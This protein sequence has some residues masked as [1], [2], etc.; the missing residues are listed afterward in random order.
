MS[1][2]S[3]YVSEIS[4]FGRFYSISVINLTKIRYLNTLKNASKNCPSG[5]VTR[6]ISKSG[7][8]KNK[9]TGQYLFQKEVQL[10]LTIF[11]QN[12]YFIGKKNWVF[13]YFSETNNHFGKTLKTQ[14][15]FEKAIALYFLFSYVWTLIFDAWTILL[16]FERTTNLNKSR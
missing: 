15:L 9:N 12:D 4:G 2:R 11:F 13:I 3:F 14:S 6:Q 1:I 5:D 16:V 10:L 7:N 8:K